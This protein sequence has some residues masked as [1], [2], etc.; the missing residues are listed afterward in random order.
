ME[1]IFTLNW[2]RVGDQNAN[3]VTNSGDG[4]HNHGPITVTA[5]G[6]VVVDSDIDVSKLVSLY[7]ITDQDLTMTTNDDGTP[8]DTFA[9]KAGKPMI[10]Y[11]GCGLPNPFASAVDVLSFKLDNAGASN[12]TFNMY[13]LVD[14]TA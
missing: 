1:H 9:L 14:N 2:N 6:N 4:E 12:A 5:S 10:W 7:I 11:S 8:D 13:C 3:N